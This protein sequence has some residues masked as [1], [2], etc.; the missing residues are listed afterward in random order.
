MLFLSIVTAFI[1]HSVVV[2]P[3]SA[4]STTKFVEWFPQDPSEVTRLHSAITGPCKTLYDHYI[5]RGGRGQCGLVLN[6]LL[7]H[8]TTE[9]QKTSIASAQV[10]L[11]LIPT[12]LAY[13]GSST[14]EVSLLASRRPMLMMLLTLGALGFYPASVTEYV[15][16]L[17]VLHGVRSMFIFSG[18]TGATRRTAITLLQYCLALGISANNLELS[19]RLGSRSVLSWGC[20]SWYMPL[21]WM[22]FSLSTTLFAALSCRVFNK[23]R[24][25][26]TGGD[27]WHSWARCDLIEDRISSC[28][29]YLQTLLRMPHLERDMTPSAQVMIWQ[30]LASCFAVV[31]MILGTL[32]LSSLIFVGFHDTLVVLARLLTSALVSRAIVLLQLNAIKIQNEE[33]WSFQAVR[34]NG[35][36]S[37]PSNDISQKHIVDPNGPSGGTEPVEMV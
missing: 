21:M 17:D 26:H 37:G 32:I 36:S 9:L 35:G 13:V 12:L 23:K 16:P 19:L 29:L 5:F 27:N 15:N 7:E 30:V 14:P 1:I 31:Q 10:A 28:L 6:C 34:R 8:G 24:L 18:F 4:F 22:L 25:Q 11:G 3:A 33:A 2:F 20:R